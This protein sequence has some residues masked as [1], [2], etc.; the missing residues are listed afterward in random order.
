MGHGWQLEAQRLHARRDKA[1]QGSIGKHDAAATQHKKEQRE[2]KGANRRLTPPLPALMPPILG[3]LLGR[4]ELEGAREGARDEGVEAGAEAGAGTGAGGGAGGAAG[5]AWRSCGAGGAAA[6]SC[7]RGGSVAADDDG[8]GSCV[9]AARAPPALPCG[10]A[11]IAM[12]VSDP[13][14]SALAASTSRPAS[15]AALSCCARR[16]E[17]LTTSKSAWL[18][19]PR[20]SAALED[21]SDCRLASAMP[22]F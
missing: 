1:G 22:C 11:D 12:P 3:I 21:S 5:G 13:R 6:A 7:G 4:E 15:C 14:N 16:N 10:R 18:M 19:S 9:A 17:V 20:S 8:R 2:Q